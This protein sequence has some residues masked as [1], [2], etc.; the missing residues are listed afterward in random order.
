MPLP[1]SVL[2]SVTG[3]LL[4]A[5]F[6]SLQDTE[7]FSVSQSQDIW[8]GFSANDV[9]EFSIYDTSDDSLLNWATLKQ[10]KTFSTNSLTFL[11]SLNIPKTFTYQELDKT[12]TLFKNNSILANPIEDLITIGATGGSFRVSY[13]FSRDMAGSPAETLSI[14]DISPSRTEVKLVPSGKADIEYNAFCLKMFP[15]RDVAPVL[16]NITKK[17]PYDQIYAIVSKL[18][19]YKNSIAFLKFIF[20]LPDDGSVLTFLK[21]LY[22]DFVQ[23][24]LISETQATAGIEPTR[25]T[26]IQGIRTYFSNYLL[27]NLDS[28]SDFDSIER[29]FSSFI[30]LRLDQ[31]FNQF[32]IQT[33]TNYANARKFC[34]DFFFR[35][36]YGNSVHPLQQG[37]QQKYFSYLKNFLNFG[38]NNYFPVLAHDFLDERSSP[39]DPLTLVIKLSTSLPNNI[40]TKDTCWISNFG[41]VPFVLTTIF[42]NPSVFKTIK[43]S[44]ANFGATTQFITKQNVNKLYSADDLSFNTE[45]DNSITINKNASLLNVDYSHFDNFIIFSSAD[46]RLNVFEG[47]MKSWT[48]LSSSL[49]L[50]NQK[51]SSSLATTTIYPYY[52]TE[53][54][55]IDD[56]MT[57]LVQSFDGFE[58]FLFNSGNYTYSILSSSFI[59]SSYIL[60]N[61]EKAQL[62]D[63]NNKDSLISNTP[64][65][66]IN[67]SKNED[68]LTF[69][70][71][72]GHHFDDIYTYIAALPIERQVKNEI[73]SSI[74]TNTLKEMLIS[75]GWN[76]DDIINSLNI[77]D[78]Y[79]NSLNSKT[80]D[81]LSA[82][83][84]LQ[85]IWNRI[86]VNL[87]GIYKT[88][89]TETCV[90]FLMS[91]YGLPSSLISVREYGGTDFSDDSQPTFKLDEKTFVTRFSNVSD[92][93]EGPI[94]NS[95]HTVEFKFAIEKPETYINRNYCPMFVSIP[96]PYTESNHR[97]WSVGITKLPG[98][99]SGQIE[100]HIES[101]STGTVITSSMLP[102][103]NGDIFS[104]MLRRNQRDGLFQS[105][106][107]VNATPLKYDL[108][109]QRNEN[110][111]RIFYS[112]SSVNLLASDNRIFSQYGLFRL[113]NGSPDSNFIGILD[114]LSI[115]DISL[116][117]L[118]FEEHVNDI[119]SYGFSGSNAFQD[120]WVRLNWDYPQNFYATLANSS[121]VW[122]DN[123]SS[124]YAIPNYYVNGVG[125]TIDSTLY[126]ASLDI[127]SS[128]WRTFYPT[129]SAIILAK[130]FPSVIDPNWTSSFNTTIC[131]WQSG[132]SYPFHFREITYQQDIN[133]SKFGPNK[134]K[135]KK[136]RKV[137]YEIEARLDSEDKSANIINTTISGESNQI[138]FFIDPQDSK[139]KDIIRYVGKEGIMEFISDPADLYSDRYYNLRNKNYEYVSSGNKR[140]YFNELLTVY[141]FYFDKSIFEAIKNILPARANI[142][143]GVVIEPTIL[144]RPKYQNKPITSSVQISYQYPG[145]IHPVKD[146]SSQGLWLNFNTNFSQFTTQSQTTIKDTLPPN[147]IA[148]INLRYTGEPVRTYTDNPFGSDYITDVLDDIQ[149]NTYGDFEGL[150][151]EWEQATVG[152]P[153]PFGFKV[154]INGSVSRKT[155]NDSLMISPDHGVADATKFYR[156]LNHGNHQIIYYMLKLWE[157]YDYFYKT[158]PYKRTD[159][160]SENTYASNS[161][162][163]YKYIMIDERFMRE[164]IYFTDLLSSNVYDPND[165]SYTWSPFSYFH[166]A[167]TFINT[168]DQLVS[169]VKAINVN[170][171]NPV[172]FT[173]ALKQQKSY[174][175]LVRGYPRNHYIHKMTQFS[176]TKYAS[177]VNNIVNVIYIKGKNTVNTTVSTTGINDG[178]S[179]IQSFNTSNVNVVNS[180]NVLQSGQ[181]G[182]SVGSV[183]PTSGGTNTGTGGSST[184]GSTGGSNNRGFPG[185]FSG[186]RQIP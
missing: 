30:N 34:Y 14:K 102:L 85:I 165:V 115:W 119:N 73:S 174:F 112:T 153:L 37:H 179:P 123:R 160:P 58:S 49:N 155:Q 53:K 57:E 114:K 170:P 137:D 9:I 186:G 125:G 118:D 18:P 84:R 103:F 3:S 79:L 131:S 66:V 140:T 147:Y 56:Q 104:V 81:T 68:Y 180:G 20:F 65:F 74:S 132:S 148:P 91:C 12:F 181:G 52:L 46:L 72:V 169:N 33:G 175:E 136:I 50:L 97:A 116:G 31:R 113:G 185:N 168:P 26:R 62:Y 44:S 87:P 117:N 51:L 70:S 88:K 90:Q 69:L 105:S 135:N 47:K 71:M 5:S 19:E 122:L 162:Y 25:I 161:I 164:Q 120:L 121:S 76:V 138:G 27:T 127:I 40:S 42:Q 145:V 23:Y 8:F 17:C 176:K 61:R 77:D 89:G 173:L 99:Y 7:L 159:N 10:E 39:S 129:G 54:T 29:K 67:D 157:Q 32:N 6:L 163:L 41:M 100:F 83:Q 128:R 45:T 36:F 144:E 108:Y 172:D 183:I 86:L 126:S 55:S 21:N 96:Y 60:S 149:H 48:S 130:N 124:Y 151:R 93:I 2:G 152:I 150:I 13:V 59:S 80:Y 107:D 133:A 111:R 1:Y 139:N 16:L 64:E 43:I 158:G 134:Y 182:S 166:R 94:P 146:F 110:G 78:V 156:G 35:F 15:V 11:D 177:F 28:V 24:T 92:Y 143:T 63:R 95:V 38:N 82:D 4:S 167:N 171:F 22:E 98:Q 154:P 184:G 106:T 141:K 178:T 75:M 109:V 142:Y 101:G